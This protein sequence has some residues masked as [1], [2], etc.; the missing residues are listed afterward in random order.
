MVKEKDLTNQE[1]I[2]IGGNSE[3]IERRRN[4]EKRILDINCQN[5]ERGR[6][7]ENHEGAIAETMQKKTKRSKGED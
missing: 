2:R 1:T 6:E 3:A 7:T 5:I 4:K